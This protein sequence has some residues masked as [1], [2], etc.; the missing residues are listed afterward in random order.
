MAVTLDSAMAKAIATGTIIA[1][2]VGGLSYMDTRHASAMDV[3]NLTEMLKASEIARYEYLI[4]EASRRIKRI[5]RVPEA[6]R[7][8]VDREDLIDLEARKEFLL[9][10]LDRLE[11]D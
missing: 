9:R 4:E 1:M 7:E 2:F 5:K 3:H 11:N 10:E 6:D 8:A